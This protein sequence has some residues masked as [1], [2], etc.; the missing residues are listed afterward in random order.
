MADGV[1]LD[2]RDYP[3]LNIYEFARMFNPSSFTAPHFGFPTWTGPEIYDLTFE[4]WTS[5]PEILFTLVQSY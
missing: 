3:Y 5:M 1:I 4:I 2:M